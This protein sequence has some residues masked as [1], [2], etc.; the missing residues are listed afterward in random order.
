[1]KNLFAQVVS[2]LLALTFSHAVLAAERGSADEAVAMVQKAISYIK[3]NGRDKAFAEINN[4]AGRFRDRDLYVFVGDFKGNVLAHGGNP[5]LVG[6]VLIDLR[7]SDGKYLVKAYNELAATKGKGWTD[8]K[9]L[10]PKTS[11]ID[12]KSSYVE[13]VDELVIGCGIYK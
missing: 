6:K 11:S 5:K 2:C 9:W 7:D 10:N 12:Q 4:P 8:Y 1:M 13:K 3:A